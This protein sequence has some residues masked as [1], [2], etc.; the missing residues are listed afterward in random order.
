[1][2]QT[3]TLTKTGQITVPKWVREILGVKPGQVIVFHRNKDNTVTMH[4]EKTAEEIAAEIDALIPEET[5]KFY[6]KHYRGLTA[7]ET[8]EKWSKTPE[9]QEYL[10]EELEKCL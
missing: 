9:A 7:N 6:M 2:A 8:F 3:A 10:K 1:M 4:R 5:R